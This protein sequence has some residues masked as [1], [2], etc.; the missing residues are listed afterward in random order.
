MTKKDAA[1]ADELWE[2]VRLCARDDDVDDTVIGGSEGA[3][4]DC[5]CAGETGGM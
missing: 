1:G 5:A 2:T 4:A 3:R